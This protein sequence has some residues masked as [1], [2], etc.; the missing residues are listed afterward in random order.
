MLILTLKK[1]NDTQKSRVSKA[2]LDKL[3]IKL[4][5][6]T[7]HDKIIVRLL[8]QLPVIKKGIKFTLDF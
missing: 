1:H 3:I 2:E 7:L 8:N 5:G 4:W 6:K